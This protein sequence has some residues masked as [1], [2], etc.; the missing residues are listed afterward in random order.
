MLKSKMNSINKRITK[1]NYNKNRAKILIISKK[2]ILVKL[3]KCK[4]TNYYKNGKEQN[5][6][7]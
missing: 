7:V 6:Y 4:A 1:N 2:N 5:K 3:L